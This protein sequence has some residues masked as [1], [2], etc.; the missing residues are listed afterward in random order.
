MK[1]VDDLYK[2][3]F[4]AYKKDYDADELSGAKKKLTTNS[5]S[6]MIKQRKSQHQ[7]KK[8]KN[9]VRRLTREKIC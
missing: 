1:H 6:C 3:Y 9:F 8:Q 4:N 7:M 2:K 5:L